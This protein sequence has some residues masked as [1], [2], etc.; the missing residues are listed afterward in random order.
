MSVVSFVFDF[1]N[2][3]D[4]VC[5]LGA[6]VFALDLRWVW[7]GFCFSSLALPT[8]RLMDKHLTRICKQTICSAL[9]A[10]RQ[11][12]RAFR[13]P[14][15]GRSG[16]IREKQQP[17]S[18]WVSLAC[19]IPRYLTPTLKAAGPTWIQMNSSSTCRNLKKNI[20]VYIYMYDIWKRKGRIC[21]SFYYL[22]THLFLCL[23]LFS[24]YYNLSTTCYLVSLP[25]LSLKNQHKKVIE[26]FAL[27]LMNKY[28][29]W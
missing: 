24:V 16:K 19:L 9:V 14:R 15:K 8:V 29:I 5:F 21:H 26:S 25:D 2:V 27:F 22:V 28:K 12:I 17:D 20:C 23:F 7:L 13:L 1:P 11:D 18:E 3:E 10:R 6:S 4:Q